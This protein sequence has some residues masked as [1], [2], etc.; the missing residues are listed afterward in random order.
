MTRLR[1]TK[2]NASFDGDPEHGWTLFH[3]HLGEKKIGDGFTTSLPEYTAS[4]LAFWV[5]CP[6]GSLVW[7]VKYPGAV[8]HPQ[9][10]APVP[11]P[12]TNPPATGKSSWIERMGL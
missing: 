3:S 10:P 4:P 6:E 1:Q 2:C 5:L 12:G 7:E 9:E 8:V 11:D